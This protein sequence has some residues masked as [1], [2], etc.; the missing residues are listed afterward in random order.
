VAAERAARQDAT[1]A[2]AKLESVIATVRQEMI[3]AQEASNQV[4]LG[5]GGGR[6]AEGQGS[7]GVALLGPLASGHLVGAPTSILCMACGSHSLGV[8]CE[9]LAPHELL[10]EEHPSTLLLSTCAPA[11]SQR[12]TRPR[13]APPPGSPPAPQATQQLNSERSA[14]LSSE[15]QVLQLRGQLEAIAAAEEAARAQAERSL[16]ELQGEYESAKVGGF[17]GC[18]G[19]WGGGAGVGA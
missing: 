2:V 19:V 5:G 1:A 13:P 8:P 6:A 15:Q 14:R 11:L 17:C 3:E 9:R 4:W 18:V 7:G 10:E 16:A 12:F